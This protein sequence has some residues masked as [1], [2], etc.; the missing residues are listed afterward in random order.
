MKSSEIISDMLKLMSKV[1]QFEREHANIS[2]PVKVACKVHFLDF[3]K[4]TA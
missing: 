4:Q 1:R 3:K 2:I